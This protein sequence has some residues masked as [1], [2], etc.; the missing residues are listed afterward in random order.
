MIPVSAVSA[1][2]IGSRVFMLQ[3]PFFWRF[4]PVLDSVFSRDFLK[5]VVNDGFTWNSDAASYADQ[6]RF[7]VEARAICSLGISPVVM[8]FPYPIPASHS[9][10]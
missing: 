9:S 1:V 7:Q 10:D 6:S 3:L 4:L 2:L 8:V 5:E